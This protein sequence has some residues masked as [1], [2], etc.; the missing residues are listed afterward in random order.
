M[1]LSRN[2]IQR[3]SLTEVCFT[4]IEELDTFN[5]IF[6]YDHKIMSEHIFNIEEIII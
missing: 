2:I 3:R 1:I 5:M 4:C 6:E